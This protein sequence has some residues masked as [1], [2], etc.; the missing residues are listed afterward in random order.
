MLVFALLGLALDL[1]RRLRAARSRPGERSRR[2]TARA[3]VG[4]RDAEDLLISAGYTIEAR[5][6]RRWG[7]M[8]VDGEPVDFEVRVDLLVR[9]G[10]E[11]FLA[12]VKTGDRAP[13]PAGP[14]TRRQLR[15]YA[16]LWPDRGLLLVDV[17]AGEVLGVDFDGP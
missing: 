13:D 4:E 9:R 12:E 5:Q 2:R 11:G 1:L 10:D 3:A 16:A 15:E 7:R 14:T 6:A 8:W 17:E